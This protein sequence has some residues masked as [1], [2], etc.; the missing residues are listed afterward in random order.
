MLQPG[1]QERKAAD[2][3]MEKREKM[4]CLKPKNNPVAIK[5][6]AQTTLWSSARK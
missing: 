6:T 1:Q 4:A 2:M 5:M 3:R